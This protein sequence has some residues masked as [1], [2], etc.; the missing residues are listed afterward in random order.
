MPRAW[1]VKE[2]HRGRLKN[3]RLSLFVELA[4]NRLSRS[5]YLPSQRHGFI[6]QRMQWRA[7]RFSWRWRV[8]DAWRRRRCGVGGTRPEVAGQLWGRSS[9]KGIKG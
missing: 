3:K 2:S 4:E 5:I 1:R 6:Q 9:L 7:R 8:R